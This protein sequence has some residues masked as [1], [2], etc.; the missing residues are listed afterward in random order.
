MAGGSLSLGFL[1]NEDV[2]RKMWSSQGGIALP[3]LCRKT[4]RGLW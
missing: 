3:V 4:I 2:L 1:R